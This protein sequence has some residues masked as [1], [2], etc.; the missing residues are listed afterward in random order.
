MK[1]FRDCEGVEWTPRVTALALHNT[2]DSYP[3]DLAVLLSRTGV[4]MAALFELLWQSC[5]DQAEKKRIGQKEFMGRIE[6]AQLREAVMA[7]WEAVG[8]AFP[9]VSGNKGAGGKSDAPLDIGT[10][11]T[12]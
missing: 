4:N 1:S 3:M 10:S 8:N 9:E 11:E 7:V 2:L 12:S 6:L 5:A